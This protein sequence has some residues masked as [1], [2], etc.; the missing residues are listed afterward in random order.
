MK[1]WEAVLTVLGLV[2]VGLGLIKRFQPLQSRSEVTLSAD[3]CS[4]PVTT[5]RGFAPSQIPGDAVILHG[6]G[7]NRGVMTWLGRA[8]ARNGLTVHLLDL[9]GHGNN[10]DPF[11]FENA[12]RC[13]SAALR[14]LAVRRL[15]QPQRTMLIGHSLGG[16]IAI[17]IAGR[18]PVSATVAISPGPLVP[19]PP[20][21]DRLRPYEMPAQV[22]R[23]L[24]VISGEVDLPTF[25]LAA[26]QLVETHGGEREAPTDFMAGA[27]L[28][29]RTL[30]WATHTGLVF[31]RDTA[32]LILS[33]FWRGLNV[34]GAY[35]D[36]GAEGF[37]LA[38]LPAGI[39]L[40]F[41]V[42]ASLCVTALSRKETPPAQRALEAA[43]PFRALPA[44]TL[45]ALLVA[46]LQRW[47]SPLWFLRLATGDY[48]AS[49][50]LLHC[51]LFWLLQRKKIPAAGAAISPA[52][53]SPQA[54]A[55][56]AALG[57]GVMLSLGWAI[58]GEFGDLWLNSERAWRFLV[59]AP[60][61]FPYFWM[62]ESLLGEAGAAP[63]ERG[64]FLR[65]TAFFLRRGILWLAMLA[66]LLLLRGSDILVLV[67]GLVFFGFSLAQWLA[68]N[69]LRR[70][71][72]CEE[73]P[74]A[75]N[76]I[77]AAWFLAAVFPLR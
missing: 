40:L 27:A 43:S 57:L 29:V 73:G 46:L 11:S 63:A 69:A 4:V 37:L 7:A 53:K 22:S 66:A 51:L 68:G 41:P 8:L 30:P 16:D 62:E 19:V 52:G 42:A 55:A 17:R 18:V 25:E 58:S 59:M 28:S 24:L 39:V 71:W 15:I 1:R 34:E 2:L 50:L 6:L 48:L 36:G 77:L 44:W 32:V 33:W 21:L 38:A 20:I 9:N 12:E 13:A 74:A 14:E 5:L 54:M 31:R 76:A 26:R 60:L 45:A 70:R 35:V 65:F 56:G 10:T 72:L 47:L 3:G 23:N 67:M 75:F 61:L 64:A 49:F